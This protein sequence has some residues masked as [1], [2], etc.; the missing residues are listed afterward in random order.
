M[1]QLILLLD[2]DY[3]EGMVQ[4]NKILKFGCVTLI[5]SLL[6][7]F[8][9][10]AVS[11]EIYSSFVFLN[12]KSQEEIV[13]LDDFFEIIDFEEYILIPLV[14][15]SRHISFDL[16][17]DRDS[18]ILLVYNPET[19]KNIEVDFRQKIYPGYPEWQTERPLIFEGDFYVSRRLVEELIDAELEWQFR[20]Q[21]LTINY[22]DFAV[23]L[24]LLEMEERKIFPRPE[25]P[26]IKPEITGS[27]VSLG[28]IHY[29]IGLEYILPE[30]DD[31]GSGSLS[32]SNR[33]NIHGRVGDWALSLG[34]NL[35]YS[36]KNET[37]SLNYPRIRA[38]NQEND[39]LIIL[40]D[41]SI[42]FSETIGRESLRGI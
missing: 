13:Q 26:Q 18:N 5:A 9:A 24:D 30:L 16:E 20:R 22:E 35:N 41:S 10:L 38:V 2:S 17:Y 34:Q 15:L 14:S 39:R 42:D 6:I 11:A 19:E 12:I 21:A 3:W 37:L 4:V 31:L 40:G 7:I 25:D 8:A 27:D 32:L 28:S 29:R 36:L 1:K 23:D 33:L